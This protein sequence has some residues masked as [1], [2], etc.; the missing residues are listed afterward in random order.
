MLY[1][2][3]AI[4]KQGQEGYVGKRRCSSEQ[5]RC[6]AILSNWS[7]FS[8]V[9]FVAA[10]VSLELKSGVPAFGVAARRHPLIH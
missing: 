4:S 7:R 9:V 5:Y 1:A 8:N 6:M 2:M 3:A 10:A